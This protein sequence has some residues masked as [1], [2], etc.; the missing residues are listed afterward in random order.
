M[1]FFFSSCLPSFPG[2]ESTLHS[3]ATVTPA[4]VAGWPAGFTGPC[5][6]YRENKGGK[7]WQKIPFLFRNVFLFC[8][9]LS[10]TWECMEDDSMCGVHVF[11]I[12]LS[13]AQ[14]SANGKEDH[15]GFNLF[16]FLVSPPSFIGYATFCLQSF[17]AEWSICASAWSQSFLH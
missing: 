16:F 1:N 17:K 8:F 3:H 9:C 14:V 2:V 11:L 15:Q 7:A 4:T 5:P 6:V 13:C 10:A 12:A